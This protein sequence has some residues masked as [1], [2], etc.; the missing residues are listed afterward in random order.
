MIYLDNNAATIVAPEVLAAM[1]APLS[2]EAARRN[3]V[4]G[5]RKSVA[6]LL[7]VFDAY[8][9]EFAESLEEVADEI[10]SS[11]TGR[12]GHL[13]TT[14]FETPAVRQVSEALE[15]EGLQVTRIGFDGNGTLNLAQL[16][17]ALSARTTAVLLN[18]AD[19][20]TGIVQP[21]NEIAKIVKTNSQ[22]LVFVD[23]ADAAGKMAVDVGNSAIDF[24]YVSGDRFHGPTGIG[25]LFSLGRD[26]AK[27]AAEHL[28]QKIVGLGVAAELA[29]DS[30]RQETVRVL[31][32]CLESEILEKI[33]NSRL[34][35]PA[36]KAARLVNT[37]NISFENTNGEAIVARLLEAGIC[38]ST[39]SACASIGHR[40]SLMLQ[41]MG[42]PYSLAMGSVRF[43]LSRY[44]TAEEI[45]EVVRVLPSVIVE[46][47]KIS[48]SGGFLDAVTSEL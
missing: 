41:A 5:A 21:L 1:A 3:A 14:E 6:T 25:A 18:H 16:D 33:P 28:T 36:D 24:Y 42:V 27:A 47:R 12:A 29:G 32:D 46:L 48:G 26:R 23:G 43:S 44:T 40:P 19:A 7:G 2:D 45:G 34:N 31:R 39:S 35:G 20:E 15:A 13:I 4:E 37:S 11:L 9:I 22:A 10:R 30:S 8:K 38:A 17:A